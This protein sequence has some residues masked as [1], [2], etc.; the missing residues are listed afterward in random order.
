MPKS[1]FVSHVYEDLAARDMVRSWSS[2]GLL[3][4]GVVITGESRDVRQL[5]ASAIR[6]R[7]SPRLTGAAAALVLVGNNSH[8]TAI[9]AALG[10]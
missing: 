9:G 7:L 4:P 10:S 8:P 1:V 3:G 2:S 6:A 5:G